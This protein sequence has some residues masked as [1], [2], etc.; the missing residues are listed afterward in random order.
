MRLAAFLE[1][2]GSSTARSKSDLFTLSAY[3]ALSVIQFC[4]TYRAT[5]VARVDAGLERACT[6]NVASDLNV[7]VEDCRASGKVGEHGNESLAGQALANTDVCGSPI[8]SR[9]GVL[10]ALPDAGIL[11]GNALVV[12]IVLS[13][14]R[15]A[16]PE[17][18]GAGVW[19]GQGVGLSGVGVKRDDHVLIAG[20]VS[21]ADGGVASE[22]V[23][24][25]DTTSTLLAKL[26]VFG[27]SKLEEAIGIAPK[28]ADGLAGS[29]LLVLRPLSLLVARRASIGAHH[30]L[31]AGAVDGRDDVVDRDVLDPLAKFGESGPAVG[32]APG[33]LDGTIGGGDLTA[34]NLAA[35]EVGI[36]T[37]T[38][39]DRLGLRL[40]RRDRRLAGRRGRLGLGSA[41][42]G[43]S[44]GGALLEELTTALGRSD[45]G[46]H[47]GRRRVQ[48]RLRRSDD[49]I[50]AALD[51]LLGLLGRKI[52]PIKN[53]LND[54]F[55]DDLGDDN[56]LA[57]LNL[58]VLLGMAM[59]MGV[60]VVMR[61]SDRSSDKRCG[62]G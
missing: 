16:L 23:A 20:I 6:R 56:L 35:G 54:N 44:S 42:G 52:L 22:L 11:N 8:A 31:L 13:G 38:G 14:G 9:V 36:D 43:G 24:D 49:N 27:T 51:T 30:L 10:V 57:L 37:S 59:E 39:A 2:D 21:T 15:L 62:D 28:A 41:G 26:R 47:S 40:D 48:R 12:D 3:F 58:I 53:V 25:K 29:T 5:V 18:V 34:R 17:V 19:V 60:A 46:R 55:G 50:V 61:L 32:F 45:G 4:N 33:N 1:D 7:K